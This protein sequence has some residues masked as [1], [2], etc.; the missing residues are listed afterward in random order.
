M[1]PIL[2]AVVGP[3]RKTAE[4]GA[5]FEVNC[6]IGKLRDLLGHFDK[7]NAVD[8][9]NYTIFLLNNSVML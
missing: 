4:C 8:I 6:R 9:D 2:W 7:N 5:I 1:P 3:T